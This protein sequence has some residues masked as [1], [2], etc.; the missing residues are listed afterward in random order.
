MPADERALLARIATGD[1]DALKCLYAV[2][3]PRLWS[4]LFRQLDHDAS[5]TEELVQDVFLAVWR[6]AG[7]YRGDAQVATWLFR[8]AHNLAANARRAHARQ[9]ASQPFDADNGNVPVRGDAY[10][11]P[12]DS[13]LDR[14][15]L[16]QALRLLS[17]K[18]RE[19][20]DLAFVQGF[21]PGEIAQILGIP[22]GTVKSRISYARQALRTHMH[23][24]LPQRG[25][26]VE[27]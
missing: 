4:Y 19:V 17:V 12:E 27:R 26:H 6:S 18:H 16:A 20:L 24:A 1:Q 21:D 13:V 23:H 11:S 25:E 22:A 10:D 3:R 14:L 2:Y 8:I 5:G 7:T 15:A 9:V